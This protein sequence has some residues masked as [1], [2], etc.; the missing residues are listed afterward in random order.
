MN[1][2]QEIEYQSV[3]PGL[4]GDVLRSRIEREKQSLRHFMDVTRRE[5]GDMEELHDFLFTRHMAYSSGRLLL[6]DHHDEIDPKVK[7]SY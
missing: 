7:Q 5:F 3:G 2:L 1:M 4:E 6:R